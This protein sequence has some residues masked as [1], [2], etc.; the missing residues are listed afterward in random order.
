MISIEYLN[1]YQETDFFIIMCIIHVCK[2]LREPRGFC[3]MCNSS[4]LGFSPLKADKTYHRTQNARPLSVLQYNTQHVNF[5][6]SV[7]IY[8][9]LEVIII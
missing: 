9:Y 2:F 5:K 4:G 3:C 6:H 1:E 7:K 8:S